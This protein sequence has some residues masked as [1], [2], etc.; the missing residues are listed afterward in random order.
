MFFVIIYEL[1][2]PEILKP[3]HINIV[4]FA[5][6]GWKKNTRLYSFS[7][8]FSDKEEIN[9]AKNRN[10]A[11]TVQF[12]QRLYCKSWPEILTNPNLKDYSD[13]E[14]KSREIESE[15]GEN[16]SFFFYIQIKS[17]F[18]LCVSTQWDKKNQ[19][20]WLPQINHWQNY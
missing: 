9:D 15:R 16:N 14:R 7:K 20:E 13:F 6:S 4:I 8:P 12:I 2:Q 10:K 5:V 18:K 1:I 3:S 11:E 19:A 17:C